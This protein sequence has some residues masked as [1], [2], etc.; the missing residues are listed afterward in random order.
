VQP[1]SHRLGGRSVAGAGLEIAG[2]ENLHVDAVLHAPHHLPRLNVEA[3]V[4]EERVQTDQELAGQWGERA[5][6]Y[7]YD[8]EAAAAAV[9]MKGK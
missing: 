3:D 4:P 6:L 2:D 9:A 7:D 5:W 8:T 1:R